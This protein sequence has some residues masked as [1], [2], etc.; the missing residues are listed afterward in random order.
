MTTRTN[1]FPTNAP[2]LYETEH[3]KTSD[4]MIIARY[5]LLDSEWLIVEYDPEEKLAFGYVVLNG[6]TFNSEWGYVSLEELEELE[7]NVRH[8]LNGR[9]VM[10]PMRVERD[11]H[12]TPAK[13][14]T[15][16]QIKIH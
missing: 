7:V 1:F 3:I 2:K 10:I 15:L 8:L 16:S 13:A 5:F 14:N 11:A 6:D 9:E 12:W 4:K